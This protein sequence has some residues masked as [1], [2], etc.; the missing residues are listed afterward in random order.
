MLCQY[1]LVSEQG[2]S[3]VRRNTDINK[4]LEIPISIPK[5]IKEQTKIANCL[6][7]YDNLIALATQ[8][9]NEYKRLKKCM[10]QK[11]FC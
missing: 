9:L 7:S 2:A 10:L 1:L 11:M 4:F 8:E 5:D 3:I 6:S